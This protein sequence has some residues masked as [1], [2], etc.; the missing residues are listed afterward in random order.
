M[1]A[2]VKAAPR[3][4]LAVLPYDSFLPTALMMSLYRSVSHAQR[5]RTRTVT[6]TREKISTCEMALKVL[7]SMVKRERRIIAATLMPTAIRT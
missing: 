6:M 1:T 4:D 3:I 5:P 7:W 2:P